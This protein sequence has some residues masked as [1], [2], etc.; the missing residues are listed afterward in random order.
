[1]GISGVSLIKKNLAGLAGKKLIVFAVGA[2]P[3]RDGVLDEVLNRNFTPEQRS[4]IRFYYLRGGF[5]YSKL[6]TP[7]KM[8]MS[9]L[10]AKLQKKKTLTDDEK[11]MLDAYDH[12]ADFSDRESIRE[13]VA[14]ARSV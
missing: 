1:V 7:N 9:L 11:G 8:L 13:L 10:K 6:D 12:P 4:L 3:V 14:Y 5:D 2:S